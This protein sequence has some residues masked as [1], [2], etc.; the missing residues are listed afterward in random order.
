MKKIIALI[1]AVLMLVSM[2]ACGNTNDDVKDTTDV[3]TTEA[4]TQPTPGEHFTVASQGELVLCTPLPPVIGY[5]F[6]PRE[7]ELN[8]AISL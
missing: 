8:L 1:L 2:V 7:E 5:G 6:P 4:P 3:D